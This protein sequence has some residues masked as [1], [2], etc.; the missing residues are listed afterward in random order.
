MV[1][2]FTEFSPPFSARPFIARSANDLKT[3]YFVKVINKEGR[4]VGGRI[5]FVGNIPGKT[6]QYVG[7]L[8]PPSM[9]E[10]DGTFQ[11]LRYFSWYD[12]KM[13]TCVIH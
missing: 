9:G 11:G 6:E 4:V 10:T 5:Q 8:L 1:I 2:M 12:L 7:I 3:N 13:F